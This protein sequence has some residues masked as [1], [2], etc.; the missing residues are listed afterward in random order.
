MARS[1][2]FDP[3]LDLSVPIPTNT[4]PALE[5]SESPDSRSGATTSKWRKK[6]NAATG[7]RS[8][9]PEYPKSCSLEDCIAKFTADEILE[10][11]NMY[12][13]EKCKKR[14]RCV[15]KL[16]IYKCPEILVD[17]LR[18]YVCHF[19][20]HNLSSLIGCTHKKISIY[21]YNPGESVH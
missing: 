8:G 13:C 1:F 20:Y 2:A 4:S 3:F 6:L 21:Q 17:V 18:V 15:R 9:N 19:S 14:Q 12:T 7:R 11:D 5:E 16:S 10:G